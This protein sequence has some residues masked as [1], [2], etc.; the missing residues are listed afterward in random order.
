M[1]RS[2]A[3][4]GDSSE[5]L[6]RWIGR[7]GVGTAENLSIRFAV[8]EREAA[9]V[10]RRACAAGLA[11]RAGTAP[12]EPALFVLTHRGL[13]GAGLARLHAC[14]V[15]P[16][17]EGHLRTVACAAVWLE[18]EL[19]PEFEVLNERELRWFSQSP[20]QGNGVCAASPYV[21]HAGGSRK[22]PDLLV[23]PMSPVNGRPLAVEVELSRKSAASLAAICVAWKHCEGVEGVLYL[24]APSLLDALRRAIDRAGAQ[25]R[26]TVLE[27]AESD[28]PALRRRTRRSSR[29]V[30][31]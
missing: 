28:V 19:S 4:F 6:L 2:G 13:R 7:H 25:R 22:R 29:A 3:S 8:S 5:V 31:A 11:R 14:R 17:A 24:A 26:I 1:M 27:L 10:L 12:G 18:C 20:A 9:G 30:A 23:R 15:A 21:H 16:R